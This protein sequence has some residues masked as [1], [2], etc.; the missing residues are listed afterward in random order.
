MVALIFSALYSC[1]EFNFYC[2]TV[3]KPDGSFTVV[4]F[5]KPGFTT[6]E[7]FMMNVLYMPLLTD[8]Y[9]GLIGSPL[10]RVIL[11]PFNIWTLEIVEGVLLM[12]M[13]GYNPAWDYSDR[14]DGYLNG[15]IK[16]G[17]WSLW[18]LLGI[19]MEVAYFIAGK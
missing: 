7:Q 5:N 4:P 19:L 10:L 1:I 12:M 13:Y 11:S 15:L 18:V 8:G 17:H 6:V 14:P 2:H 9:R 3:D 16:K